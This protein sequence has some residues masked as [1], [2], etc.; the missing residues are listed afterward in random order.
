[1][2]VNIPEQDLVPQLQDQ[3]REAAANAMP[4]QIAGSGSKAFYGNSSEG[5]RLEV[6][7]HSGI[8]DYDPA[9]LVIT[10]RAG[11]RLVDVEALLTEHNQMFAFEPP[12]FSENATIGGIVATGLAGPRRAF[13]GGVRDS[14]L[15]VKI[16]DGRGE[17]LNFGGRVIKNVAGFDVSRLM[18][19][20]MG[21]LGVL[22]EASL[23]VV[24]R[25]E[26]EQTLGFEHETAEQHIRWI[27][28]QCGQPYPISATMWHAGKSMI[29]LSASEQGVNSAAS[30]LGGESLTGGW[31]ALKEQSH[32]FFTGQTHVSRISLPPTTEFQLDEDQL[33]EWGGAQRWLVGEIDVKVLRDRLTNYEGNLCLFRGKDD[34]ES[35]FQAL[36]EPMLSLHRNLK[37]RFDPARIFNR[38]RLFPGL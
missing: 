35:A 30:K 9:E 8:I 36:D 20:S 16:L 28:E 24:P 19:G 27:N 37:S 22:L 2:T 10:L 38:G 4:L 5:E 3:I 6:A 29:R 12:H 1:M 23:R 26:C 21:T 17:V 15:G 11:C 13:S 32:D 14:I 7:E 33:I 25:F 34:S 18:A 31:V